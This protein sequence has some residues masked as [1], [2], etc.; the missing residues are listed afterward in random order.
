MRSRS[1]IKGSQIFDHSVTFF[2]YYG[3]LVKNKLIGKEYI[4][5]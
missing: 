5:V 3:M 1:L 4:W 2:L